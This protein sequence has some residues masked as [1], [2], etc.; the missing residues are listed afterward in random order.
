MGTPFNRRKQMYVARNETK[1]RFAGG[2]ILAI[3]N[4]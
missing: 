1:S 4:F 3:V 2:S